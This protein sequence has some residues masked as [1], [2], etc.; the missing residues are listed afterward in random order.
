M[1]SSHHPVERGVLRSHSFSL[2]PPY[3]FTSAPPIPVSWPSLAIGDIWQASNETLTHLPT[4]LASLNRTQA[5]PRPSTNP[6]S[7]HQFPSQAQ[8]VLIHSSIALW[9]LVNTHGSKKQNVAKKTHSTILST[10]SSEH[11]MSR[12]PS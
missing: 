3:G 8:P 4:T 2:P 5:S 11:C 9:K 7:N 6:S 1:S 12:S 10:I